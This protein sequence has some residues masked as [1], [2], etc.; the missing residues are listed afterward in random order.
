MGR[1]IPASLGMPL[2]ATWLVH[3]AISLA[4]GLIISRV[5]SGL[6]KGR[7]FFAGA[8]T[9]LLLYLA[10][11]A[12]ISAFWPR[13]RGDEIAVVFTHLV[14]GLIA[15]GAYRGLLRRAPVAARREPANA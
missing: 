8:L 3:L 6:R 5:V 1:G 15:A 7:A 10:N 4:Y 12:A 13:L 2:L 11:F 14:F 9:G